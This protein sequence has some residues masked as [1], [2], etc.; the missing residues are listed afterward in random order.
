MIGIL[1]PMLLENQDWIHLRRWDDVEPSGDD[2]TTEGEEEAFH[3]RR[4][5]DD[6]EEEHLAL[7]DSSVV[8][9]VDSVPS[10]EDTEAFETDKSAPTPP[11]PRSR[12]ARIFVRFPPLMT[13]SIAEF[14][15]HIHFTITTT[16]TSPTYTEAPLDYRAVGIQL[17]VV[18]PSIH[19][20]SEIPSPP[21]LLPST[22]H[23]EDVPE[24][25][26]LPRKRLCLTAPTFRFKIRESST[27]AAA[28][29]PGSSMALRVDYGFM[30]TVDASIR[31]A[32]ERAMAAMRV[33]NLRVSYQEDVCRRE[34]KEFY[35]CHKDAQ[36]DRASVR[37]KIE[38]LSRERLAYKRERE[39]SKT[40]H[41]LAR[42]EAH[43]RALEAHIATI[44]TQL[45]RL[46]WHHQEA[47]DHAIGSMM[48]IHV[49][50]ARL[51]I[52][53]LEDTDSKRDVER[54]R[55]GNDSHD[56]RSD[57]RRRMHVAREC[58]YRDFLKCQPLNFKGEIK[59]LEIK[60]RNL[61]VKG[62]DVET[63]T[64]RFQ[65]LALLCGE[66]FPEESDKVEKYV[67]GLLM[68]SS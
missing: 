15:H 32:K 31:A 40:L 62:T 14:P 41:A 13:T 48:R 47:D 59:K 39:S 67:G 6:E 34:S 44:E 4:E 63:Y 54:S 26:V 33:I 11:P 22:S 9:T 18:S 2:V 57:G 3:L 28:R 27:A 52:D 21:L 37:S 68:R 65:E 5:N 56:S 1:E 8:P 25:D 16:H 53:I 20:P 46:E 43:N 35:T 60:I 19:H 64:Q 42:S 66:M 49:L 61:K 38:V 58:T 55:N 50:E 30:D 17:R 12:R 45:Y 36:D 29:Q 24:A 10:A 7:A 51:R 23:K